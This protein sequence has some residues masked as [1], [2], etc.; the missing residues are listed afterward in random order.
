[1]KA[2]INLQTGSTAKT[3]VWHTSQSTGCITDDWGLQRLSR[4]VSLEKPSSLQHATGL[5][6]KDA[7]KQF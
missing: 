2:N 5:D 4:F 7:I 6:S 1:M 3:N